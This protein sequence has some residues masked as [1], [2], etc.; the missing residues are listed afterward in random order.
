MKLQCWLVFAL[1]SICSLNVFAQPAP[2]AVDQ[3][4]RA[5]MEKQKIPGLALLVSRT[6]NRFA[7]RAMASRTSNSRFQ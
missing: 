4:V 2:D 5:E 1:V 3:Y 7:R 6:A